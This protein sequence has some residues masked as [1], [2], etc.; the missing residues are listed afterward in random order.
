MCLTT[1]ALS[2]AGRSF[3]GHSRFANAA[4][5]E[6]DDDVELLEKVKKDRK[7]RLQRQEIINSSSKETGLL[8]FQN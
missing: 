3:L 8:P 5:L 6:A 4:V 7:K 1:L 2:L